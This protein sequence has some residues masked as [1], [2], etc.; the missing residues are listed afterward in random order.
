MYHNKLVAPFHFYVDIG[1]YTGVSADSYQEFLSSIK[2]VSAKSLRFHLDR[3]D[4]E[5]WV[6]GVLKDEELAKELQEV[7]SQNLYGAALQNRLDHLI[8]KRCQE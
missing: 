6:L 5:R 1:D 3:G 2:K 7:K 8:S 4:F